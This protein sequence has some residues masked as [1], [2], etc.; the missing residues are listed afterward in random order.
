MALAK[1]GQDATP[2]KICAAQL[3]LLLAPEGGG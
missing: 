2:L 3:A 1:T